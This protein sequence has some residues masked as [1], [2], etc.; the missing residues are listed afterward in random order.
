MTVGD[1]VDQIQATVLPGIRGN[2]GD[3]LSVWMDGFVVPMA[4]LVSSLIR[5]NDTL[6]IKSQ[7]KRK[8]T[9]QESPQEKME[10]GNGRNGGVMEVQQVQQAKEAD[11]EPADAIK[12]DKRKPKKSKSDKNIRNNVRSAS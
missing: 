11:S 7:L 8:R 1:L 10:T 9:P 2:G 4:S 12:K 3:P 6:T 5:D